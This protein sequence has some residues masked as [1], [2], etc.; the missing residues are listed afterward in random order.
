LNRDYIS[1][2][3]CEKK[4]KPNNCCKGSCHL[5]KELA[6]DEK[7]QQAPTQKLKEQHLTLQFFQNHFVAN[8][9]L[10]DF[11][12]QKYPLFQHL[13]T[14]SSCFSIFHPPQC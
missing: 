14:T 6:K 7:K 3:L 8:L 1:K 11:A 10:T 4:D 13:K 12:D 9:F 5:K 2:N